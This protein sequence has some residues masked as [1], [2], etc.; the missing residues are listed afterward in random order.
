MPEQEE[1]L[2]DLLTES[3]VAYEVFRVSPGTVYLWRKN[4]LLPYVRIPGDSTDAIRY[5]LEP[6]LAWAAT[7]GVSTFV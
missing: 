7:E 2:D 1:V 5:R 6:L 3:Q 4:R